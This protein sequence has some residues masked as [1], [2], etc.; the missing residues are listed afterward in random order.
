MNVLAGCR[1]LSFDWKTGYVSLRNPDELPISGEITLEACIRLEGSI[2]PG[3]RVMPH[4]NILAHGHDRKTEVERP[5]VSPDET[6]YA[7]GLWLVCEP[8]VEMYLRRKIPTPAS[9]DLSLTPWRRFSPYRL[10]GF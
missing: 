2:Q 1:C 4:R 9:R 7:R 6:R 3:Q 10:P 5:R 8:R